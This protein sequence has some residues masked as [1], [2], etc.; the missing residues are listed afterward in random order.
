MKQVQVSITK[1]VQKD[2]LGS[3]VPFHKV[4]T[5]KIVQTDMT[6]DDI[7]KLNLELMRALKIRDNL[8][9][10]VVPCQILKYDQF[11][12]FIVYLCSLCMP[13]YHWELHKVQHNLN[14][15]MILNNVHYHTHVNKILFVMQ[16]PYWYI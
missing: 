14:D 16:T 6:C 8:E 3:L 4:T 2:I 9:K 13:I 10:R 12:Q 7:T 1:K 11:H 5:V 15:T